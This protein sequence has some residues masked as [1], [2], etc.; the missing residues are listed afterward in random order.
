MKKFLYTTAWVLL[1][2]CLVATILPIFGFIEGW[3]IQIFDFPRL[4]ILSAALIAIAI[5]VYFY[6]A[7]TKNAG[8][9]WIACLIII[10]Y[11]GY[12]L[13]PY[14]NFASKN[15][16]DAVGQLEKDNV[17][18]LVANVLMKNTEYDKMIASVNKH[19]PDIVIMLEPDKQW[20]NALEGEMSDY[21]KVSAP[22]DNTYGM[23]VYSKLPLSNTEIK[24][25]I[26]SDI[27]SVF[28]IA[29]HPNFKFRLYAIHPRPPF[30][31]EA[32][33]SKERDAEI[34]LT[35]KHAEKQELP[36]I[37]AGDFNDVSW[38]QTT[39]LFQEKSQLLDPREGRGF[40]NTFSANN[41]ILRWPLDHVFHSK[42]FQVLEIK[43]LED[44]GSDHFPLWVK[45][46]YN[47]QE[48]G[49]NDSPEKDSNTD[50]K[51]EKTIQDGQSD[52]DS[53]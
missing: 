27:P 2:I 9:A 16:K 43:R 10:G 42:E 11:Q 33:D 15:A 45:L 22:L 12:K 44:I 46:S 8:W 53:H 24:Y 14:T 28:T 37:V 51:A 30:P 4:Q 49:E 6:F 31:T 17:S 38:S 34:I 19:K 40:I 48:Q 41:F 25:Q 29:Q 1:I 47:P 7:H 32:S 52:T 20:E 21:K 13:F 23:I 50:E 36:V 39:N 3:Y 5:F 18:I 35:A 26:E